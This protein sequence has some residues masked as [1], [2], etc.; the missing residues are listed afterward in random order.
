MI[1]LRNY[2]KKLYIFF[3]GAINLKVLF[4]VFEF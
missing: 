1:R 4:N 2:I 3:A